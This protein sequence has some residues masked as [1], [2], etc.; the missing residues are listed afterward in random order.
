MEILIIDEPLQMH[1]EFNKSHMNMLHV[2]KSYKTVEENKKHKYC[3]EHCKNNCYE[4]QKQ[5]FEQYTSE[6]RNPELTYLERI[7]RNNSVTYIK[8]PCNMISRYQTFEEFI[9]NG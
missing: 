7:P 9:K 4:K 5:Y 1:G 8:S 2:C 6:V 3:S